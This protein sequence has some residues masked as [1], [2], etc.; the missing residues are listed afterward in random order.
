MGFR[1]Q[2]GAPQSSRPRPASEPPPMQAILEGGTP[3]TPANDIKERRWFRNI[4]KRK[5][6]LPKVWDTMPT[7]SARDVLPPPPP[8]PPSQPQPGGSHA[9]ISSQ[10]GC[11]ADKL[12]VV[13]G[14]Y[15]S[16]CDVSP[17]CALSGE[18]KSGTDVVLGVKAESPRKQEC[19][20]ACGAFCQEREGETTTNGEDAT[21]NRETGP[22]LHEPK[23]P[24]GGLS[25]DQGES[26]TSTAALSPDKQI[27]QQEDQALQPVSQILTRRSTRD[28]PP[29]TDVVTTPMLPPPLSIETVDD[30]WM[31]IEETTA[32]STKVEEVTS[33]RS[34]SCRYPRTA[35]ANADKGAHGVRLPAYKSLTTGMPVLSLG[36]SSPR[37]DGAETRRWRPAEVSTT[38][39]GENRL[40]SDQL[41]SRI[42]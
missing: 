32:P 8:T 2:A 29:V 6:Q 42:T 39:V 37:N 10:C 7:A 24:M 15:S 14:S 20:S 31:D 28:D 25:C 19:N 23:L 3:T 22:E 16:D 38:L 35:R 18:D 21:E 26:V 30:M 17:T 4:F 1:H 13:S 9:S 27:R 36:I 40:E 34:N 33:E 12:I 41:L 11:S 5:N